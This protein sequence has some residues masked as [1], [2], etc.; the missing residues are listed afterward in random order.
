MARFTYCA[1]AVDVLV[2]QDVLTAQA[3]NPSLTRYYR[4]LKGVDDRTAAALSEESFIGVR[5]ADPYFVS[6]EIA[7]LIGTAAPSLPDFTLRS[8]SLP[9]RHG[10]VVFEEP[11]PQPSYYEDGAPP[12]EK[13]A[14]GDLVAMTWRPTASGVQLMFYTMF[15]KGPSTWTIPLSVFGWETG[16]HLSGLLM[17]HL[18]PGAPGFVYDQEESDRANKM[19]PERSEAKLRTFAAFLAFLEQRLLA[20]RPERADRG[21]RR[22]YERQHKQ[23]APDVR[24]VH[25]RQPEARREYGSGERE[26]REWS[27]RWLVSGHW[28]RQWYGREKAHAPRWIAPYVKGDA[29]RPL[30]P[31]SRRVFAVVR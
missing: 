30:K 26:A 21:T 22:R 3:A 18:A 13:F 29:S 10:L 8:E 27:C 20:T 17:R 6:A 12:P 16:A 28:R 23:E 24:V 15:H 19:L 2:I 14:D 11:V 31:P 9:S 4:E 7:S 1:R 25:L 5:G